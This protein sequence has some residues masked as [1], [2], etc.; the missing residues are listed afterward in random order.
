M[1]IAV[2]QDFVPHRID[3]SEQ[4]YAQRLPQQHDR[5][6][7]GHEECRSGDDRLG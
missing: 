6:C 5:E 4:S 1:R 2:Q 7:D 3:E